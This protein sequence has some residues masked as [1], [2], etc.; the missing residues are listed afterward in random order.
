VCIT[1][2]RIVNRWL[3]FAFVDGRDKLGNDAPILTDHDA[4]G[5]G[6]DFDRASGNWRR[7]REKDPEILSVT[8]SES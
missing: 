8:I 1:L 6:L 2:D 3:M 5:I 4:V 7:G